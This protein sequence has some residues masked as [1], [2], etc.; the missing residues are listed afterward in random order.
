MTKNLS[1]EKINRS[2]FL[3]MNENKSKE[4]AIF[5]SYL[6]S[7]YS[8]SRNDWASDK[9]VKTTIAICHPQKIAL[10]RC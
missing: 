4:E 8:S 9:I 7:T 1:T 6:Y 10:S 2:I 5:Y 3:M